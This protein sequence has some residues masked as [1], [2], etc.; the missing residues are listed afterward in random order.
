MKEILVDVRTLGEYEQV[1]KDG[2]VN[3]PAGNILQGDLGVIKDLPKDSKIKCY[4]LSGSRA[5]L[6]REILESMGYTNVE[7]IG[8]FY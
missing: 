2:A 1:H 4:C 6:V 5:E 7:N 8:G 3:I